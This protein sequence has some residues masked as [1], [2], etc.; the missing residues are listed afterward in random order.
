MRL[1]RRSLIRVAPVRTE[2]L[3]VLRNQHKGHAVCADIDC[4]S[5]C[6]SNLPKEGFYA[7]HSNNLWIMKYCGNLSMT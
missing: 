6:F 3:R 2:S 5:I 7:T 1:C 4:L